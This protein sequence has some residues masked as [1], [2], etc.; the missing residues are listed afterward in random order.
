MLPSVSGIV[1]FENRRIYIRTGAFPWKLSFQYQ[2]RKRGTFPNFNLVSF[3]ESDN[4]SP[5]RYPV[6]T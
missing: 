3:G 5:M 4:L 6:M 1:V 2:G